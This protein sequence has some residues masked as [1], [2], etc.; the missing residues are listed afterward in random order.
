MPST[1]IIVASLTIPEYFLFPLGIFYMS[2]GLVRALV[3]NLNRPD[4]H[5]AVAAGRLPR[6][7]P[8]PDHREETEG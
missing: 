7:M 2:Y 5:D 3:I 8:P 1:V 6:R 4:D